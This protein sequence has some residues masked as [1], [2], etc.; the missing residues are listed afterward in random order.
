MQQG[1][2]TMTKS[3]YVTI[4]EVKVRGKEVEKKNSM[5]SLY[6]I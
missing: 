2:H 4:Y 6:R 3:R 5:V 1:K